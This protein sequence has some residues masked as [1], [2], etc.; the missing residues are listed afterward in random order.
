MNDKKI[1]WGRV[2]IDDYQHVILRNGD[3]KND[4]DITE[5]ND[6]DITEILAFQYNNVFVNITIE[7]RMSKELPYEIFPDK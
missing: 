6:V 5:I 2:F 3:G 4:V 1:L 7:E